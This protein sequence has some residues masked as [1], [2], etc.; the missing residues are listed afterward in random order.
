MYKMKKL[1]F[2]VYISHFLESIWYSRLL[3]D[4]LG[5]SIFIDIVYYYTLKFTAFL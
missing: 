2:L 3:L 1:K 5:V 4:F